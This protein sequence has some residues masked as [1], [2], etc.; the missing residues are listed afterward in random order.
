[1]GRLGRGFLA[2]ALTALATGL[3][4]SPAAAD[5]NLGTVAGLTYMQSNGLPSPLPTPPATLSARV[6][7]PAG[8]HVVGGGATPASASPSG[9]DEFWLDGIRPFDGP[10]AD[11]RPDDGWLGRGFNRFGT[12]KNFGSYAICFGGTVRYATG[13]NSAPGSRGVTASARC[14]SGTHVAGGGGALSGFAQQGYL[15]ASYPFD[16]GD[17]G[18]VADDGWRARAFNRSGARKRLNVYATCVGFS[19]QHGSVPAT[20]ADFLG[21][22]ACA[23][24]THGMEGGISPSGAPRNAFLTTLYPYASSTNPPDAGLVLGVHALGGSMGF[25]LFNVCKG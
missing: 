16:D 23:G 5:N 11:R 2:V 18:T 4:V 7:C 19:P 12:S 17:P 25:L 8:T 21:T 22:Y 13:N 9:N 24:T 14:P 15:N 6:S 1:M 20:G 3:A 10:D